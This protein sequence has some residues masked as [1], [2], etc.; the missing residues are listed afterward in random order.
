M[1][2]SE[3]TGQSSNVIKVNGN[4][5][6]SSIVS[7]TTLNLDSATTD[8]IT[9]NSFNLDP[10]YVV[11]LNYRNAQGCLDLRLGANNV[12]RTTTV[13]LP[14]RGNLNADADFIG[15]FKDSNWARG[16]TMLERAGVFAGTVGATQDAP[17][18]TVT[19]NSSGQPVVTFATA[20]NVK[21]SV[22]ASIDDNHYRPLGTVIGNGT[23]RTYTV[24]TGLNASATQAAPY[25]AADIAT[26]FDTGKRTSAAS[27]F[28]AIPATVSSQPILFRVIAF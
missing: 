14:R 10:G 15:A 26:A 9:G 21:Y 23:V 6:S 12:A 24:S 1:N 22:E 16:W 7:G 25:V 19:V 4:S 20:N 17:V 2:V 3:R 18:V 27:T 5:A 28:A 8:A 13:A 11:P